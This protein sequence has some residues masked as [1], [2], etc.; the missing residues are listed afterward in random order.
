MTFDLPIQAIAPQSP[1]GW[2]V[3][4]GAGL[5]AISNVQTTAADTLFVQTGGAATATRVVYLATGVLV[6]GVDGAPVAP[7]DLLLP[8]P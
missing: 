2:Q 3:Y 1:A 7:F 8:Y 5:K 4:A 6:T